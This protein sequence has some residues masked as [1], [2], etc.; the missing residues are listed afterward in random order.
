MVCGEKDQVCFQGVDG[1]YVPLLG[2]ASYKKMGLVQCINAIVSDSILDEFPE[3]FQG[4]DCLPEKYHISIDPSVPS[5]VHPP[6]RAPHSSETIKER[7]RQDGE[8]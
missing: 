2:R 7:V 5:V 6:R 4:L 3:V 8:R 1:N